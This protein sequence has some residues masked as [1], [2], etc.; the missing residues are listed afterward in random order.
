MLL[1]LFG[2]IRR[3]GLAFPLAVLAALVMFVISETSY[4][5]AARAL[6][7]LGRMATAREN[8]HQ[9][10]RSLLDAETGQRGYLLTGRKEYL[11]PHDAAQ[12]QVDAALQQLAS[13]HANDAD[14]L[15]VIKELRTLSAQKLSELSTSIVLY[16]EGRT[17]A[18]HELLMTNIGQETMDAIRGSAGRLLAIE[19]ARIDIGQRGVDRTLML[20]RLGVLAMTALSLLALF[21]YLRQTRALESQRVQQQKAL[22]A[23]RDFLETEVDR[24]TEQLTELARHLQT[25]REDERNR[26]A[27]DLH[28]ELGA[29][30]TAAKLDVARLKSRLG[31]LTPEATDRLTHLNETLNSGIALK[32]RIIEDLRPSSLSNLGLVAALEILTREFSD[33]AGIE[34]HCQLEAVKLKP[35]A[36]LMVYRLVQEALTNV[37]KYA[38][39][40]RVD[41]TL[42]T[43]D[44]RVSVTVQDDGVGFEPLTRSA[45][46]GLLGMRY[47][48]ES[49]GGRMRLDSTPGHGTRL[50]ASL[51]Q[52]LPES[53]AP[54]TATTAGRH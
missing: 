16:D 5:E 49:E 50:E 44:R 47:R 3:R 17:E 52:H 24:R 23:E 38:S 13:H 37:A 10:W 48:V 31:M 45:G 46:H 6:D 14:A 4:R 42:R 19:S 8:I 2:R 11:T 54:A 27:R 18:W 33:R 7:E 36:E 30:L 39:A 53:A 20:N 1:K 29:L 26:L 22:Q 15:P 43:E 51:P 32:R 40:S 34:V 25:A 12:K 28:D 35:S 41:V 21:M 9:V